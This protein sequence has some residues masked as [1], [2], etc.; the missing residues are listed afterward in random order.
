VSCYGSTGADV[1]GTSTADSTSLSRTNVACFT[2]CVSVGAATCRTYPCDCCD[3]HLLLQGRPPR[4]R[5]PRLRPPRLRSPSAVRCG[6]TVSFPILVRVVLGSCV[7]A[8][9]NLGGWME[10]RARKVTGGIQTLGFVVC[11]RASCQ[12][13]KR[14]AKW[15]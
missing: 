5:P 15:K 14:L 8:V 6:S 7:S 2:S 11:P 3:N 1:R 9:Q 12:H 13:N 10:W 4:L